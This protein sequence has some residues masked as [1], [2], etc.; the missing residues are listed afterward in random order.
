MLLKHLAYYHIYFHGGCRSRM[1]LLKE[2]TWWWRSCL[3]WERSKSARW[4]TLAQG[5]NLAPYIGHMSAGF[6]SRIFFLG[7][8]LCIKEHGS[9]MIHIVATNRRQIFFVQFLLLPCSF[10]GMQPC[11]PLSDSEWYSCTASHL[12]HAVNYL[13]WFL[14]SLL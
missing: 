4:R 10:V 8:L 6:R 3:P 14:R 13:S 5:T 11:L 1:A 12:D 9:L 2:R 7:G